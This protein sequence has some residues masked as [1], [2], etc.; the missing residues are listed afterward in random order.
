MAGFEALAHVENDRHACATLRQ[1]RPGW[2]VSDGGCAGIFRKAIRGGGKGDHTRRRVLFA[3]PSPETRSN[4]LAA[5][6]QYPNAVQT[7][8]PA[9]GQRGR[10]PEHAAARVLPT[11]FAADLPTTFSVIRFHR[12]T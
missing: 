2:N 1:N 5:P 9:A 7:L 11:G 10:S 12:P 8:N 4:L 6:T 3:A